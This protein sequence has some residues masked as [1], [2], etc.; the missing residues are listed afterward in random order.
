MTVDSTGIKPF[1]LDGYGPPIQAKLIPVSNKNAD[2]DSAAKVME[3][4]I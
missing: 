4:N 2:R 1:M 3:T